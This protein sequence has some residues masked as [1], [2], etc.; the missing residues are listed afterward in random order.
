MLFF[1]PRQACLSA[2][3]MVGRV[4]TSLPYPRSLNRHRQVVGYRMTK[5]A[6][7]GVPAVDWRDYAAI[8]TSV[9]SAQVVN[10]WLRAE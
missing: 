1:F 9:T 10:A 5:G 4:S 3:I 6:M 2:G 7:G 8:A